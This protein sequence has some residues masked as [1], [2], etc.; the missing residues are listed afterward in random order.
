MIEEDGFMRATLLKKCLFACA[1]AALAVLA[2]ASAVRGEEI[3]ATT[4]TPVGQYLFRFEVNMKSLSNLAVECSVIMPYYENNN[5]QDIE[6]RTLPG[7]VRDMLHGKAKFI[8][9]PVT[10]APKEKRVVVSEFVATVYDAETDFSKIGELYPYDKTSREYQLYTGKGYRYVDPDSKLLIELHDKIADGPKNDLEFARAAFNHIN[11]NFVY[12][13]GA[14]ESM[15]AIIK[16]RRGSCQDM[17]GL[18][19]SLLRRHGIPARLM[20]GYQVTGG[21]HAR[22]EFYL[23]RY[24]W[25]PVDLAYLTKD[26]EEQFFGKQINDVFAA[27][28]CDN[29]SDNN[30]LPG[31]E[32]GF[33]VSRPFDGILTPR[34]YGGGTMVSAASAVGNVTKLENGEPVGKPKGLDYLRSG[35]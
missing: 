27:L 26:P 7:V 33:L 34:V 24:G 19:V 10:L 5:Y 18:F 12:S 1:A 30:Y 16:S 4:R 25:I 17:N 15:D 3:P 28:V 21:A 8:E 9:V 32:Y 6:Y 20:G 2:H 23:E 13:R 11:K 29:H 31:D 14:R 22:A 35:N